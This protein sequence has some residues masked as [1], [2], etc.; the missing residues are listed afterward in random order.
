MA[1]ENAL[2]QLPLPKNF[3][4]SANHASR[5]N[6]DGTERIISSGEQRNLPFN[7]QDKNALIGVG[8]E[9]LSD[10]DAYILS[11]SDEWQE[12]VEE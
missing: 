5:D 8:A 1:R 6:L 12:S 7:T 11:C 2:V 4:L 10:D 9:F 3:T